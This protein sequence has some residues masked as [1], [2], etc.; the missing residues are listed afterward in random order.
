MRTRSLQH[1]DAARRQRL[2]ARAR[3]HEARKKHRGAWY[4]LRP[5]QALITAKD[6]LSFVALVLL[7]FTLPYELGFMDLPLLPDPSSGLFI[8][9]RVIDVIFGLDILLQFFVAIPKTSDDDFE[10]ADEALRDGDIIRPIDCFEF[11]P[12]KIARHYLTSWLLIDVAAMVPSAFEIY[13]ANLPRGELGSS[14]DGMDDPLHGQQVASLAAEANASSWQE[15]AATLDTRAGQVD[16][17]Q[18]IKLFKLM[19]ATRLVRILRLLRLL[20]AAKILSRMCANPDSH[21]VQLRDTIVIETIMHARKIRVLFLIGAILIMNHLFAC[22]LGMTSLLAD[23]RSNSWWG[24]HGYCYPGQTYRLGPLEPLRTRC[25]DGWTQ[26]L[27]CYHIALGF[28]FGVPWSEFIEQGPGTPHFA[29]EGSEALFQTGER[30]C[31]LV[32][33]FICCL[34][35]LYVAGVFVSV[36][37]GIDGG[38]LKEEVTRFCSKYKM[39]GS[40]HRQLQEYLAQLEQLSDIVPQPTLFFKLSPALSYRLVLEIHCV[41]LTKLNFARQLM[42]PHSPF[43]NG[44]SWQPLAHDMKNFLAQLALAMTPM[45]FIARERPTATRMYVI[46]KGM[47]ADICAGRILSSGD[48]WGLPDI[49]LSYSSHMHGRVKALMPLQAIC[50]DRDGLDSLIRAHPEARPSYL[51][52]R[53]WALH[54]RLYY[55]LFRVAA[56][57]KGVAGGGLV[58]PSPSVEPP[59]VPTFAVGEWG[60]MANAFFLDG[61]RLRVEPGEKAAFYKDRFLLNDAAVEV[62]AVAQDGLFLK[63]RALAGLV[64]SGIATGVAGDPDEQPAVEG[65]VRAKNVSRH[66]RKAGLVGVTAASAQAD[67]GGAAAAQTAA[68]TGGAAATDR[69]LAALDE[70]RE[71]MEEKFEALNKRMDEQMEAHTQLNR[72]LMSSNR[73]RPTTP[74]RSSSAKGLP[75]P[76]SRSAPPP[77]TVHV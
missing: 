38:S 19:R 17:M 51:R 16:F 75:N 32:I 10:A 2:A 26:Y 66:E 41:W 48:S 56:K 33:A 49:I 12:S 21:V 76:T 22:L 24:T 5:D 36:V 60:W 62:L 28:V 50:I 13:F 1:E 65:W 54:R 43:P 7:Y 34:I 20:S 35:G 14:K 53:V 68:G 42:R 18:M 46:I 59:R 31:F 37:S 47:A 8:F 6:S 29:V 63:V 9:N 11:R 71:R 61:T 58:P 3:E 55:G 39:H 4:I 15:V 23:D 73:R 67:G 25:V 69:V 72:D 44:P 74:T 77:P 70:M 52:V 64:G 40:A 30:M 27:V 45:L 57:F